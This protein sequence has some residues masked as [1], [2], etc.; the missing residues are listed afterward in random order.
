MRQLRRGVVAFGRFL[1]EFL[2]GDTPELFVAVVGIVVLALLLRHHHVAGIVV[3]LVVAAAVLVA[4][5][6]R[7]RLRRR[8]TEPT[9]AEH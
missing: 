9:D 1:W 3:L 8:R 6:Y 7:G 4:S 2:I 5:T